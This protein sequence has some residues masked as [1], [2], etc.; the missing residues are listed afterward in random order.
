[1]EKKQKSFFIFVAILIGIGLG[2]L[3]WFIF[4]PN[5]AE[6]V[7]YYLIDG[8][9]A[10]LFLITPKND[11]KE[12]ISVPAREVDFGK[13][14]PPQHTYISNNEEQMI[15]FKKIGEEPLENIEEENIVIVR[16][17]S[18]PV[19]VN[20]KTGKE[21]EIEQSIDSSSLV[22]SPNDTQIAWIKE[23]DEATFEDIEESGKKR[24]LWISRAD[25]EDAKLINSF[26][27]NVI[28]LR[29]WSGD[30]IYFQGLWDV[31]TRSL[32]RI[33]VETKKVDYLVPRYCGNDLEN[34]QNIEFSSTGRFF[35]YEIYKKEG[36]KEITE[37]YLGDFDKREFTEILTTDRI[38][39]RLWTDGEGFFYTEQEMVRK[40][41]GGG[42]KEMKETI[43]L[44]NFKNETDDVIYE[45]SYIS[46][47][48]FSPGGKYLYF[49]EK[50]EE[51]ENDFNFIRLNI[52]NK[53]AETILTE[54]FNHILLFGD[55]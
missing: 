37:L 10:K 19:L 27:E 32:G 23:V 9:K 33:N 53:E 1:M 16:V 18:K 35:I 43:H 26:D 52:K 46:Q 31:N 3:A 21:T 4:T 15:Y 24:E 12:I 49:L 28:L 47:L 45:G 51:G 30:Y 50:A 11:G 14:K 22:F 2:A 48:S 38:S 39:D 20:L 55:F 29:V 54:D 7:F 36:D 44:V 8:N 25:G 13:Y 17:I 6:G 42:G 5:L 40:E 41:D 34:C